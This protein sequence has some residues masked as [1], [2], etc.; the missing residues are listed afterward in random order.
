MTA[1]KIR[2]L[3]V[4]DEPVARARVLALLKDEADIEVVGE[5]GNGA[6]AAAVIEEAA[7]DPPSGSR[8]GSE[9]QRTLGGDGKLREVHF[10]HQQRSC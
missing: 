10:W 8:L 9:G 5:C 1:P 4:D 2:T 6:Q 3:V 7:P